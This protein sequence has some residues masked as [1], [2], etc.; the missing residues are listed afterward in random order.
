MIKFVPITEYTDQ[1]WYEAYLI[2]YDK[3]LAFHMGIDPRLI[4]NPP[5]LTTFYENIMSEVEAERFFGFAIL[6]DDEYLGHITLHNKIGEWEFGAVLKDPKRWNSGL[7]IKAILRAL[8]WVFEE[9]GRDW[10]IAFPYSRD[11]KVEKM[12]LKGGMKPFANFYVIDK[13]TWQS[14]WARRASKWVQPHY[15]Q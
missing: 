12:L 8:W 13:D 1:M 4:N 2:V 7:G 11:E 10:A 5:E 14:R 15:Q 6:D 9:V 3:K